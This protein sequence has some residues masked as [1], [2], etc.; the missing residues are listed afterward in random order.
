MSYRSYSLAVCLLL[1]GSAACQTSSSK[2]STGIEQPALT[3]ASM[4]TV[5]PQTNGCRTGGNALGN[6]WVRANSFYA[7]FY[8]DLKDYINDNSAHFREG[9]DAIRCAAT[10]SKA[11][12]SA[13]V[14][15]YDPRDAQRWQQDMQRLQQMDQENRALGIAPSH[16]QPT[17][18]LS[19]RFFQASMQLSRLERGLPAAAE[20]D[21]EPYYT[22]T[23]DWEQMQIVAEQ[24]LREQLKDPG[25]ASIW[26]QVLQQFEPA[27]REE[28]QLEYKIITEAAASL[29]TAEN[30]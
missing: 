11:F 8:G 18:T 27:L 4:Q 12:L 17:P 24:I 22:P 16:Q 29:A 25:V 28:A 1:L 30:K 15:A 23:N 21:W 20:G 14:Q 7:Y 6:A 5:Q 2:N 19:Q 10:L 3:A 26:Q 13:S 9:A